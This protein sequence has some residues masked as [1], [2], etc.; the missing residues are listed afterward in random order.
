MVTVLYLR[1]WKESSALKV[2]SKPPATFY[3]SAG[4][5]SWDEESRLPGQPAQFSQTSPAQTGELGGFPAV[6]NQQ[7]QNHHS[8]GDQCCYHTCATEDSCK[9]CSMISSKVQT[10]A[11]IVLFFNFIIKEFI[12]V[13]NL[14]PLLH[15]MH[16]L[17][18][19]A[20]S[21]SNFNIKLR[22]HPK[23]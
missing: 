8:A 20:K 18:G 15:K 19:D 16:V 21:V 10:G 7:T 2:Y 5:S 22:T 11:E 13:F 12:P 17:H 1:P 4:R 6:K 3:L 9:S 14:L 23:K